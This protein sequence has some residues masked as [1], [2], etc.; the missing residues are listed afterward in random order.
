M[1]GLLAGALVV[2]G[3]V[4]GAL[5]VTGFVTGALVGLPEPKR[6]LT[7]PHQVDEGGRFVAA[8]LVEVE[9]AAEMDLGPV[10]APGGLNTG[11]A[12]EAEAA[13]PALVGAFL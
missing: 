1:T 4:T 10:A 13:A 7:L 12:G 6:P 11:V 8:G 9:T 5:V 3:F 2:R